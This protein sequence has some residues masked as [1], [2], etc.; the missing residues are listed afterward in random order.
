MESSE[1]AV[2]TNKK[3]RQRRAFVIEFNLYSKQVLELHEM[4][5]VLRRE[6]FLLRGARLSAGTVAF[7]S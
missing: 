2:T 5:P 7:F 3:A 4:S 6:R 1:L